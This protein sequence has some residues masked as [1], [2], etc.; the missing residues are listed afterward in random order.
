MCPPLPPFLI[1]WLGLAASGVPLTPFMCGAAMPWLGRFVIN[2]GLTK[3]P[4]D[5]P[6][7]KSQPHVQVAL[8]MKALGKSVRA[9]D[10]IPYV[11]CLDGTTN[12]A[13]C[14]PPRGPPLV[15]VWLFGCLVACFS[16]SWALLRSLRFLGRPG[17]RKRWPLTPA[18]GRALPTA[19]A[20][21]TLTTSRRTW[22]SAST[23]S[24]T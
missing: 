5:Y 3:N 23:S 13:G 4:E 1:G 8:R 15:F 17:T 6:D 9:L 14:E 20:R 24:T 21:T 2:K 12:A 19:N 16:G 10:T 7:K 22:R 18:V 11:I